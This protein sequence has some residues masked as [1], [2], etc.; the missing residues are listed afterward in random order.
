[1]DDNLWMKWKFWSVADRKTHKS[2]LWSH[3]DWYLWEVFISRWE[4]CHETSNT[5]LPLAR[6]FRSFNAIFIIP[7]NSI[8][9]FYQLIENLSTEGQIFPI[10]AL[11]GISFN[12]ILKLA[13]IYISTFATEVFWANYGMSWNTP[14][15]KKQF[16]S[17][18]MRIISFY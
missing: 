17:N 15:S 12:W 7:R 1:M 4:R 5:L 3:F 14:S 2:N 16:L 18:E 6:A 11:E 9:F 8:Y 10:K 13:G